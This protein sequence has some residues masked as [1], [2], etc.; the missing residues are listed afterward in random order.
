M[1][2][3]WLIKTMAYL[4]RR[5]SPVVYV[6]AISPKEKIKPHLVSFYGDTYSLYNKNSKG[7]KMEEPEINAAAYY[8][9]EIAEAL[10]KIHE[11]L[12]VISLKK[13]E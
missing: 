8:L 13:E 11:D 2:I 10:A 1:K 3:K 7:K 12:Y 9:K 6:S 5:F 4:R